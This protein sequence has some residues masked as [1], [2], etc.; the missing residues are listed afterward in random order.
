M[1]S[2]RGVIVAIV[3][4][5]IILGM[6]GLIPAGD[7]GRRGR[8]ANPPSAGAAFR[9]PLPPPGPPA[10]AEP[11][12]VPR[13]A[14]E[15]GM[16]LQKHQ[17]LTQTMKV[18]ALLRPVS[19]KVTLTASDSGKEIPLSTTEWTEVVIPREFSRYGKGRCEKIGV[20][21]DTFLIQDAESGWLKFFAPQT[22]GV[23]TD[24]AVFRAL[25][26]HEDQKLRVN[27]YPRR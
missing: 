26:L 15:F 23:Y 18:W 5:A 20:P 13:N 1:K 6:I 24:G 17:R 12:H 19:G 2:L 10:W 7:K 27:L 4:I 16:M 14:R 11:N 25:G 21:L 22:R 8:R 9:A 3:V